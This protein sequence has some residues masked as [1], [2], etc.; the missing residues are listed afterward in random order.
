VGLIGAQ[1]ER[2]HK[3]MIKQAIISAGGFGTRL[4]PITET[5]PKPMIPILGKPILEWHVNQ[6]KKFGV[7]EFFF[8]LHYLPQTIIDYFDDG[9][10]FG[11]NIS[12]IVEKEPLGSA[13]G[14]KKLE[15]RLD[16]LFFYIYGDAFSLMDYGKMTDAYRQKN[17][18]I[19]MQRMKKTDDYADA[20]IAELDADGKFVAIHNKPHTGKYPNAYRMR[21]AFI[22][23]KK[24][25]SYIP[26]NISFDLG[27]QLLPKLI[28]ASEN[29]YSYEC[30]D[31]SK[32]IDTVEKW[33]EA[34]EYIKN[35][36]SL[37][38]HA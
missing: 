29:F 25:L 36:P 23:D 31:Y 34:E 11:V 16:N 32:G 15:D 30:D 10:K 17:N 20:D 24:T 27:K 21:G 8:T 33:K 12:Y 28:E 37:L 1:N 4:R 35:N 2:E 22:L 19:G 38:P 13:G 7:T 18:P 6:F 14:I 3:K 26:E 5:T 9:S